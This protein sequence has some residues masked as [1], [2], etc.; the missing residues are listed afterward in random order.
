MLRES[1][2]FVVNPL[3]V[4]SVNAAAL[5]LAD[6][7]KISDEQCFAITSTVRLIYNSSPVKVTSASL[8]GSA[9]DISRQELDSCVISN[10]MGSRSQMLL[11]ICMSILGEYRLD[12]VWSAW[13]LVVYL[14]G[15]PRGREILKTTRLTDVDIQAAIAFERY[16]SEEIRRRARHR[17]DGVDGEKKRRRAQSGES[18]ED[19]NSTLVASKQRKRTARG[20]LTSGSSDCHILLHFWHN[21]LQSEDVSVLHTLAAH[22]KRTARDAALCTLARQAGDTSVADNEVLQNVSLANAVKSAQALVSFVGRKKDEI[23]A[24]VVLRA[25]ENYSGRYRTAVGIQRIKHEGASTAIHACCMPPIALR[26]PRDIGVSIAW[27]IVAKKLNPR[28]EV[29]AV[30]PGVLERYN[31]MRTLQQSK[32]AGKDMRGGLTGT[33]LKKVSSMRNYINGESDMA[34]PC[35]ATGTTRSFISFVTYMA[36]NPTHEAAAMKIAKEAESIECVRKVEAQTISDRETLPSILYQ[37]R[38]CSERIEAICTPSSGLAVGIVINETMR[39]WMSQKS[40]KNDPC[41]KHLGLSSSAELQKDVPGTMSAEPCPMLTITDF[42]IERIGPHRHMSNSIYSSKSAVALHVCGDGAVRIPELLIELQ[43]KLLPENP[44]KYVM[45]ARA[46]LFTAASQASFIGAVGGALTASYT[47][48]SVASSKKI[49]V[50]AS[51]KL[52]ST[53]NDW[54]LTPS[55][56]FLHFLGC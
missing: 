16:G 40:R 41:L 14:S 51:S 13:V 30:L 45:Q 52:T 47:N 49:S 6:T 10:A 28:N 19:D 3:A 26:P 17:R 2:A 8:L 44:H 39:R 22:N 12:S 36:T 55:Y 29:T 4:N 54:Q 37:S 25:R 42:D 43:G 32:G 35:H 23:P 1:G 21:A 5:C 11:D 53:H 38:A 27:S 33:P 7:T 15:N 34:M 31:E 24:V 46:A 48:A 50:N 9:M 20:S 56:T 18:A